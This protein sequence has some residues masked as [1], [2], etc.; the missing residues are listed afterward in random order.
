MTQGNMLLPTIF[1]L[2]VDAVVCHWE[3]VISEGA[4]FDDRYGIIGEKAERPVRQMIRAFN[5]GRCNMEGGHMRLKEVVL[6]AD[7]GMV[8]STNPG[9]LHTA[10]DTL[11]VLFDRVGLK[12]NVR[13]QKRGVVCHPCRAVGLWADEDYTRRVTGAE[14]GYKERQRERVS[15][16]ECKK[17]LARGN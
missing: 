16:P 7:N 14:R 10:V 6:Y 3:S 2:A 5:N 11:T 4:G 12:T 17:D 8:S 15:C 13:K 1:N 9:W